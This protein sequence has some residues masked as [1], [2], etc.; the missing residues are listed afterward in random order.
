MVAPNQFDVARKRAQQQSRGAIQGQQ[1]ALKRRFASMGASNSGAA[2]KQEQLAAE[3]GQEQLAAQEEAI[4]AA[5]QQE[6]SRKGEIA[7]AQK[8]QSGEAD[9]A[10]LFAIG[11]RQAGESFQS[12]Q[13]KLTL[14]FQKSVQEFA[15]SSFGQQFDL[16][17]RELNE[18]IKNSDLQRRIEIAKAGQDGISPEELGLVPGQTKPKKF[19]VGAKPRNAYERRQAVLSNIDKETQDRIDRQNMR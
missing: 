19:A 12:Q 5:E 3:K 7:D 18:N 13:N 1:E 4:G 9:K 15:K 14:D 2:L 8:F 16:S 10:R 6:A 11:E 17:L